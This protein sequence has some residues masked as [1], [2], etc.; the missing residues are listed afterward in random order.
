M[1]D[2][3]K[4]LKDGFSMGVDAKV[5]YPY[6]CSKARKKVLKDA[7]KQEKRYRKEEKIK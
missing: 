7:K 1:T 3:V 5:K 2:F 4:R 6:K